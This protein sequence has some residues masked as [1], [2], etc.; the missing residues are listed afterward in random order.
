MFASIEV[1]HIFAR[2][3]AKNTIY[4]IH[5]IFKYVVVSEDISLFTLAVIAIIC[6]WVTF[7]GISMI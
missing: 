3:G 1:T 4:S 5:L 7:Y 6:A 2:K